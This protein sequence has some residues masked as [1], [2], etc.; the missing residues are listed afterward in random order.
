MQLTIKFQVA[1]SPGGGWRGEVSVSPKGQDWP[2]I[3]GRGRG[4]SRPAATRAAVTSALTAAALPAVA[5]A[6]PGAAI[7]L[8]LAK[9]LL[10]SKPGRQALSRTG[11]SIAKALVGFRK[12]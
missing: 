12:K 6:L 9:R 4:G 5:A 10:T 7:P 1:P 2:R 3:V 8:G 11:R